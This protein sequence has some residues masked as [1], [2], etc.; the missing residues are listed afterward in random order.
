VAEQRVRQSLDADMEQ[1]GEHGL[2]KARYDG[3]SS[4]QGGAPSSRACL[5]LL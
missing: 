3:F 1:A 2:G 5:T 4:T